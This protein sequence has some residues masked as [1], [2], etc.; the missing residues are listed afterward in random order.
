MSGNNGLLVAVIIL[1]TQCSAYS[2]MEI[3]FNG[4]TALVTGAGNGIYFYLDSV[5]E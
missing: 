3:N 4:K 1:L 5:K 2:V